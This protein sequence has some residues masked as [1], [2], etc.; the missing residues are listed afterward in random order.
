MMTHCLDTVFLV[1]SCS[2][3]HF[4]KIATRVSLGP[5]SCEVEGTGKRWAGTDGLRNT[6]DRRLELVPTLQKKGKVGSEAGRGHA[7]NDRKE[8]IIPK[9]RGM[10]SVKA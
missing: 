5:E 3:V 4:G 2:D 6:A 8:T 9:E 1:S 10:N 7:A